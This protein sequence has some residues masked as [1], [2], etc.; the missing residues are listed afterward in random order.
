MNLH[1]MKRR[2]C[3]DFGCG[4]Y[5]ASRGSRKHKGLDLCCHPGTVVG[6]PVAGWVTK[7]GWPYADDLSI[8]YVEV[9][10]EGYRYRVFYIEPMVD[11][12]QEVIIGTLI[13]RSQRLGSRYPR[14]SEHVHFEIIGPDGGYIDPTA[15]YLARGH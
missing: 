8:R 5:N 11:E 3:D 9:S 15:W 7:L 2:K 13:G 12:G 6:S 14:I 4:H 1:E 10:I